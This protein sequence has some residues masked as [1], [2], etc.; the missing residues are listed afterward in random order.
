[1]LLK[2]VFVLIVTLVLRL[3]F[4]DFLVENGKVGMTNEEVYVEFEL[5]R[6]MDGSLDEFLCIL[7]N[8]LG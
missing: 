8:F 2:S 6:D 3:V 4:C 1:M 7:E 5:R